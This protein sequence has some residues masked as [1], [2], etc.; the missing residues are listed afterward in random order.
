MFCCSI[1]DVGCACEWGNCVGQV[2]TLLCVILYYYLLPSLSLRLLLLSRD[3]NSKKLG[4]F[5]ELELKKIFF[6]NSNLNSNKIVRVH[7]KEILRLK[8]CRKNICW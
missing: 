2:L 7:K 3:A 8:I 4:Y 1:C 6:L 5:I